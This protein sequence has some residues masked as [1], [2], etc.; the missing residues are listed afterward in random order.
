[1]STSIEPRRRGLQIP[2]LSRFF[3]D[4][5]PIDEALADLERQ[6]AGPLAA[7]QAAGCPVGRLRRSED[8][9]HPGSATV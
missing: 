8:R 4:R 3:T 5:D 1:M 6:G 7:L 9:S 2:L